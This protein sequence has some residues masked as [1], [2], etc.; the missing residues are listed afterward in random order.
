MFARLQLIMFTT[1]FPPL[2]ISEMA[3]GIRPG[4]TFIGTFIVK[5][6]DSHIIKQI[7][8]SKKTKGPK[9]ERQIRL[10]Y[11]DIYLVL[12]MKCLKISKE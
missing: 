4:I 10:Q 7:I 1:W 6:F 8:E 3:G 12:C 9:L 2:Y 11:V 5:G